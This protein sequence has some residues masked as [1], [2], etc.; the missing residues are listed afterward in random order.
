[1]CTAIQEIVG[2]ELQRSMS[3]SPHVFSIAAS[4]GWAKKWHSFL[5]TS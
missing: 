1:L 2:P 3:N 4:T 5:Y